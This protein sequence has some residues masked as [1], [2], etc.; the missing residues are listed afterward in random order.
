MR[1]L[2]NAHTIFQS[3]DYFRGPGSTFSRFTLRKPDDLVSGTAM[4]IALIASRVCAVGMD[5]SRQSSV[6]GSIGP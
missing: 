4:W 1:R 3:H 5:P 2:Q 6:F